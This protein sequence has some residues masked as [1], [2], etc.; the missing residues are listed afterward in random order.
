MQRKKN[1]LDNA[2]LVILGLACPSVAL[3]RRDPRIQNPRFFRFFWIPAFA[4]MTEK[5]YYSPS[6]KK[7]EFEFFIH[8]I[9]VLSLNYEMPKSSS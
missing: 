7:G 2:Y 4:G 3:W 8:G 1:L 6:S 9:M 5:K